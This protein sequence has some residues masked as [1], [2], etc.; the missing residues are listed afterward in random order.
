MNWYT[1]LQALDVR[2]KLAVAE[3]TNHVG[4]AELT[5]AKGLRA[6]LAMFG[7]CSIGLLYYG[8]VNN[9]QSHPDLSALA[10]LAFAAFGCAFFCRVAMWK[11]S[12]NE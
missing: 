11:E 6:C 2:A 9:W 3:Y 12:E 10:H 1:K 8:F 7:A 5:P 4:K